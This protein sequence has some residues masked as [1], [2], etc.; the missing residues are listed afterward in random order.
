LRS[1]GADDSLIDDGAT[2]VDTDY[3]VKRAGEELPNRESI[4][5]E[6]GI[7]GK[8]VVFSGALSGRKGIAE[9]IAGLD[10][11]YEEGFDEE[12]TLVLAGDGPERAALE[13]WKPQS[14]K[15]K[16]K[17]LG[18]IQMD[19]L[20]RLYVS[21]DLF[22]LPTLEDN[23]AL[24]TLEPIL[25]GT[26]SLI[27]KYNGAASDL[28]G[29]GGKVFD[30]K[31]AADFARALREGLAEDSRVSAERSRE[32]AHFYHPQQQAARGLRSISAAL[33]LPNS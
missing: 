21:G 28:V 14:E 19:E 24:A 22:V 17:L 1:L 32:L 4:R 16:R 10:R 31:D 7:E 29:E 6:L 3:F 18:F 9:L 30:P 5:R 15:L 12:V 20:P 13:A 27:S 33:K 8:A 26:P 11:L 23:W 2:G 25:C